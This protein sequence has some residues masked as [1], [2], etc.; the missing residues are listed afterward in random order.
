MRSCIHGT[1]GV[2][3]LTVLLTL[4]GCTTEEGEA[5]PEESPTPPLQTAGCD[6]VVSPSAD[7]YA[8]VQGAFI[9]SVAG[10]VICLTGGTYTFQ[11]ELSSSTS[12]V[13]IRGI[14]GP[15]L[16]F[17]G[18]ISGANGIAITGD[19]TTIED[20]TV[21]NSAGDGVRA[22]EVN[23][24]TYRGISVIWDAGPDSEN[25]AYGVYPVSCTGVVIEDCL[26]SG[27]S[28]AGIYVGQSTDILVKDSEVYGN[29]AGIEIENSTDAEV[30]GNYA[31][32]NTGGILVFNLPG[33]EV[34]DGKRAKVHNNRVISNNQS[35]F[36]PEGN[37]VSLVPAGT[38]IMVLASD[39]NEFH[40]N[41]ITGNQSI[42]IV[43]IAY[44]EALGL[45]PSSDPSF[46]PYP[47]GN[48]THDNTFS[49]NGTD[50]K[51]IALV[52]Q[53]TLQLGEPFPSMIWDG[54]VRPTEEAIAGDGQINC[55]AENGE[56]LYANLDLCGELVVSSD[57]APVTCEYTTLPTIE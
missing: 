46:D 5:T 27:A 37:I 39:S 34:Q 53:L 43:F 56:T 18:Q 38:G 55:F 45:D 52:L 44:T 3:G 40:D 29:V 8:A 28:D 11:S 14:E 24:I 12:G 6:V 48:Y 42:G 15:I 16:D 17:S 25:G 50:P 41:E 19:D 23:N 9:D 20:L 47:E 57:V 54:C 4:V 33:L 32:D 35:N 51:D 22:T 1:L 2:G 31:H 10:S 30:V 49:G 21:L 7:D 26:V 36:A 13:T